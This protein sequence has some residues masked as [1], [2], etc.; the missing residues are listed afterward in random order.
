MLYGQKDEI[1]QLIRISIIYVSH[2]EGKI[3]KKIENIQFTLAT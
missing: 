1:P 3:C 2:K